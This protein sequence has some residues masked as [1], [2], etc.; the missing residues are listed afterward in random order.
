MDAAY[1]EQECQAL[2]LLTAAEMVEHRIRMRLQM[3]NH[4]VVVDATVTAT[5]KYG[6]VE[7]LGPVVASIWEEWQPAFA[8]WRASTRRRPHARFMSSSSNHTIG[9]SP[10]AA[11]SRRDVAAGRQTVVID[12]VLSRGFF[13]GRPRLVED[14]IVGRKPVRGG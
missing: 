12:F 5:G 9:G 1:L 3:L 8:A 7:G 13:S 14:W 10:P 6:L 11:C 4:S 2:L